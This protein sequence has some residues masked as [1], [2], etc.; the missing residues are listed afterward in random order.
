MVYAPQDAE[1]ATQEILVKAITKL[2]SFEGRS[3]FRTWLY[4]IATHHLLNLRRIPMEGRLTFPAF[5]AGLDRAE[6]ADLPDPREV[7]VD[8]KLLVE[9]A[10]LGCTMAMLLCLAREQ[11]LVYVL[12]EI[13]GA[14]D[15]VAAEVLD[16]SRDAFRQK[17]SRARRDLHGFMNDKCGL[18]NPAR[19][20]RCERKTRA[21]MKAGYVDPARLL[22]ARERVQQVKEVA[23]RSTPALPGYDGLCA[24]LHRDHP[25]HDAADLAARIRQLIETPAFRDTFLV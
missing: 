23:A 8:L 3:A 25:F 22:F 4:R 1:D 16:V 18:V 5:A 17:L 13:L 24:D 19:P 21:F 14:S 10:K 11:R 20:C 7:P 6:E 12:G 15:A 2:G 9:E